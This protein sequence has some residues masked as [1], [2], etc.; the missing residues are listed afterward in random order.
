MLDEPQRRRTARH[1]VER[2]LR[3]GT[4]R[5]LNFPAGQL[6][7]SAAAVLAG[8]AV[9]AT[10][11]A[12]GTKSGQAADPPPDLF[13]SLSSS[14]SSPAKLSDAVLRG[15]IY[16]YAE[17]GTTGVSQVR[18]YLDD[19][20]MSGPPRQV[21][22]NPP[23]DFAGGSNT[24]ANPF[25]TSKITDGVH[26]VTAVVDLVAGEPRVISASFTVANT[27]PV[28]LT[29]PAISGVGREGETLSA[30][31]GAWTGSP[32]AFAYEWRRCN[33]SGSACTAIASATSP[34]Y[35]AASADVGSTLRVVVTATNSYGSTS[36]PSAPLLVASLPST[37]ALL[38][39]LSSSRSNP[40]PLGGSTVAGS[41]TVSGSIYVFAEPRTTGV[42]QVRFYFDDPTMSNA[43]WRIEKEAPYD[44]AGATNAGANPFDTTRV[45]NGPHTITAAV[46]LVAGGTSVVNATFAVFNGSAS[47][48]P[49]ILDTTA[50][51]APPSLAATGAT[52]T[53]VSVSWGASSD[54][55]GVTAYRL[56]ANGASA[57]STSATSYD[58]TGLAC[59]AS[60]LLGVEARDAAGN[61]SQRTTLTASTSACSA[62]DTTTSA[63]YVDR[64]SRGGTCSDTRSPAAAMSAATPWCSLARAVA[65]APSGSLVLVRGGSY[66]AL[67]V[68]GDNRRTQL[69]TFRA[70][71]GESV[72][73]NG[74]TITGSSFLRF[75]GFKLT[76][77]VDVRDAAHHVELVG[78]ELQMKTIWT[79]R[80]VDVLLAGNHIHDVYSSTNGWRTIGIKSRHDVR[81]TIRNNRIEKLAEDPIQI[82]KGQDV[83]IEAN[84]LR[85]AHPDNGQHTDTIQVLGADRLTIRGNYGSD[86]NHGLMFTD[87]SAYNVT[88]ENN[89]ITRV[90]TGMS[91]HD[92]GDK[93]T[94]LKLLNNTWHDTSWGVNL[95]TAHP[96][97]IVRNNIFDK[98]SNLGSQPVAENN[99]VAYPISG[100]NYGTRAILRPAVFTDAASLELAARSP[101][102][103]AGTS[104]GTPA[105]DR[106]GRPRHDDL[107][108][109]NSGT[110]T[111]S[112]TDVGAHERQG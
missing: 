82:T 46:D 74:L 10:S 78:N 40:F 44:F 22:K 65:G 51:S 59:G 31:T 88:I 33:V 66:P 73:I 49:V 23:Y 77:N 18:F 50:P 32:T 104:V 7:L 6:R 103:D 27:S 62:S 85:D 41:I 75:E 80:T 72:V 92:V 36:A 89:V 37:G 111:V 76:G 107:T 25:D 39:S 84:T 81:L 21:E 13:F 43:V 38:V 16:A 5:R 64:D 28:N 86:I 100:A 11:G 110:G 20:K 48:D 93:M 83:L 79:Y 14:R 68:Y 60:Y 61:V 42:S 91:A 67:T 57:G 108:V 35:R 95:R 29:P 96:N 34:T 53:S 101:G 2:A 47:V 112:Y 90:K 94:N 30:S 98:V 109:L 55:V 17:A 19:P 12:I 26:S 106:H 8:F 97:A 56:F 71:S 3:A 24:A 69:V 105:S 99:L 9:L 87:Y 45:A 54:N 15:P 58:F 1:R 102:I 4:P 52:Q 70:H 63:H